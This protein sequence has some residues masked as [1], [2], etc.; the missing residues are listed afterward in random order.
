[1]EWPC[2]HSPEPQECGALGAPAGTLYPVLC[3][4]CAPQHDD[5]NQTIDQVVVPFDDFDQVPKGTQIQIV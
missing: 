3:T 4:L 5:I 2:G 1:M